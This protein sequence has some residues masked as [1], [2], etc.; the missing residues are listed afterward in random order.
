M[1]SNCSK[2]KWKNEFRRVIFQHKKVTKATTKDPQN[3]STTTIAK[4]PT[5]YDIVAYTWT[6][7]FII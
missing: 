1:K 4:F 3:A 7:M 2:L 5:E 6:S